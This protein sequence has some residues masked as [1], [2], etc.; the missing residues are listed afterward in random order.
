LNAQRYH[1][2]I[3]RPIFMPC[4][5]CHHLMFQHDNAWP[6]VAR[7]CT[8]FHGLHTH[9]ICHPL[10]MFGMLWIDVYDN[11]LQFPLISSN[12]AQPLKG[13][14]QFLPPSHKTPEWVIKW[15]TRLFALSV[16]VVP[17]QPH[18][19]AAATLCLS[20]MHSHFNYTFM[21]ILP[22]LAQL[23]GAPAHWLPR[24]LALCI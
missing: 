4:I 10:S 19:Y 8:Q 6:Y 20:S 24:L 12:F 15:L 3:L 23:T 14:Q 21:H 5:C 22:Q 9:Q 7:I 13:S 2:E 18:F 16:V 17:R 1:D 11:M